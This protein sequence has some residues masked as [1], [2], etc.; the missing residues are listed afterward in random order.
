MILWVRL[1]FNFLLE[2][3]L[4]VFDHF[5]PD[6]G[7]MGKDLCISERGIAESQ[8]VLAW[9]GLH[10]VAV[11]WKQLTKSC[12][13]ILNMHMVPNKVGIKVDFV[14]ARKCFDTCLLI[15]C[16]WEVFKHR[17]DKLTRFIY[18]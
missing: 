2:L 14:L 15:E 12:S 9:L 11:T 17:L 5:V 8:A 6:R 16:Y 18:L 3:L 7:N 10:D 4:K 13:V 1:A